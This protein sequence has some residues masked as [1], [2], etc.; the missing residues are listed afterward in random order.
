MATNV[1]NLVLGPASLY[2]G[3]VGATEPADA[4]VAPAVAWTDLGLTQDGVTLTVDQEFTEIEADQIIDIAG[5]RLTKRSFTVETNL[6]ELTLDNLKL[7]LNG[8]TVA[9]VTNTSTYTPT[10]VASTGEPSYVALM[11]DGVAPNGK[12]RRIIIRKALSTGGVEFAY[13]KED[14]AVYSVTF[15]AHYVSGSVAPFLVMDEKAV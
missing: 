10:V 14:Q 12:K 9:T 6:A 15:T 7:A 3:V 8:G 11:I 1:S 5:S 4:A 2:W 13:N